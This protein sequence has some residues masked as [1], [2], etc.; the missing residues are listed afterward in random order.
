M[1]NLK[2][3]VIYIYGAD[4]LSFIQGLVTQ[5]INNLQDSIIAPG[6][7]LNANGKILNDFYIFK[8]KDGYILDC[9]SNSSIITKLEMYIL[10]AQV[11]IELTD[12]N[13]YA[14]MPKHNEDYNN[15]DTKHIACFKH[16]LCDQLG[17]RI[18]T[19]S[20]Y[21]TSTQDEDLYNTT[22]LINGIIEA[23]DAPIESILPIE[24]GFDELGYINYNKGC[25]LGQEKTNSAKR[26]LAIRYR[27]IPVI[28]SKSLNLDLNEKIEVVINS[29]V[30]GK[31]V[32]EHN[33]TYI[34]RIKMKA[35][36]NAINNNEDIYIHNSVVTAKIPNYVSHY[37]LD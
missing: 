5:D 10:R 18:Y 8:F 36:I 27:Y 23:S 11:K 21:E 24:A 12:I 4:S 14:S 7:L 16:P 29:Q 15:E 37:T 1:I 19:N 25:Y 35:L 20:N 28:A 3:Q 2:R 26:R 22:R 6:L 31:V 30:I 13:V 9:S 33:N 32:T 34:V 17:T